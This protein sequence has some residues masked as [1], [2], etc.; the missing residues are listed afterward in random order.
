[1]A[2]D[3]TQSVVASLSAPAHAAWDATIFNV[4]SHGADTGATMAATLRHDP[5][6]ALG[7]A[8]FGLLSLS[9]AQSSG[10]VIAHEA[11]QSSH[12]FRT[13]CA[14]E[15]HYRTALRL[16]IDGD[17]LAAADALDD[18][19][20]M[21]PTDILAFKIAHGIRFMSGDRQGL[22]RSALAAHDTVGASPDLQGFADG[23][24]AFALEEDGQVD[25]AEGLARA[26]IRRQPKDA[27]GLHALAHVLET[28]GRADEGIVYLSGATQAWAHCG[29]FGGHM[30]WHLAL[31]LIAKDRLEEALAVYDTRVRRPP[32]E[33][34]RDFANAVSLL[35]RLEFAGADVGE[36]WGDLAAAAGKRRLDVRWCFADLHTL[37]ALART[38]AHTEATALARDL[39]SGAGRSGRDHAIARLVAAPIGLGL[40][41]H[42]RGQHALACRLLGDACRAAGAIG[43]SNAQRDLFDLVYLDSLARCRPAEARQIAEAR[44]SARHQWTATAPSSS[45]FGPVAVAPSPTVPGYA[46]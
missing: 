19:L 41:A 45:L 18:V 10:P 37:I 20:V 22:L 38:G 21:S 36:R 46:M 39:A 9:L 12:R 7:H 8:V 16:W 30:F 14:R 32:T 5:A 25:V 17:P 35:V 2:Q 24:A 42:M 13:G 44:R 31:Y 27:W 34:V 29:N 15:E 26:A 11:L 6:F 4:L 43:G 23:C 40:V 1:M 33:D 28:T 3:L